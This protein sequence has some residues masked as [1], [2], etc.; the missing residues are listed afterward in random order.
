MLEPTWPVLLLGV[1][2]HFI[3]NLSCICLCILHTRPWTGGKRSELFATKHNV[4]KSLIYPSPC[5]SVLHFEGSAISECPNLCL[6]VI[7][8]A[9]K[10]SV[11]IMY[12]SMFTQS[13]SDSRSGWSSTHPLKLL[14]TYTY[15][16][17]L[18]LFIGNYRRKPGFVSA[19]SSDNRTMCNKETRKW[20]NNRPLTGIWFSK[21]ISLSFRRNRFTSQ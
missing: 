4:Q 12:T 15:A 5:L 1:Y 8:G 13:S 16:H 18:H 7:S 11:W 3:N 19:F 21:H 6:K 17:H 20:L 2:C 9:H 14:H 10:Q